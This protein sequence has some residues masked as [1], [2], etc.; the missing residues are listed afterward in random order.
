MNKLLKERTGKK[1]IQ[2]FLFIFLC[3]LL[4]GCQWGYRDSKQDQASDYQDS[5][6]MLNT[7][8][9]IQAYGPQAEQAVNA[10]FTE[11]ERLEPMLDQYSETGSIS[12]INRHFSPEEP[13]SSEA[14]EIP[15]EL[16]GL[17]QTSLDYCQLTNGAFDISIGPLTQLWKLKESKNLRPTQQELDQARILVD[18]RKIQ[19]DQDAGTLKMDR[20]MALDL[21]AAAKG[22]MVD[23]AMEEIKKYPVTGAIIN[24][25]GNI[26][27][28]GD[29]PSGE[30]EVGITDPQ[31]PNQLLT[32]L[33]FPGSK[34][35]VS[36]GNYERAYKIDGRQFGHIL[37]IDTGWPADV[38][39][40]TAVIG[41]H[42][43]LADITSTSAYLLGVGEGLILIKKAGYEGLIVD[44]AGRIHS[45]PGMKAYSK[46]IA[47]ERGL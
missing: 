47:K 1:F 28:W 11:I 29:N 20:G 16:A 30:W 40:G 31:N 3:A 10:A 19:L 43:L 42:S 38:V 32:T 46:E 44:Q 15:G 8:I 39:Q 6:V 4:S 2:G 45:T 14:V 26:L 18:Y 25:G 5:R 34:A 24:A 9:R 41:S 36:A 23:Q 13:T 21:G 7:V 35:I 37:N 27:T 17:I 22:Y 12:K 33:R